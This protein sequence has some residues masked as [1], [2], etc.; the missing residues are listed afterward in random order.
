MGLI[1]SHTGIQRCLNMPEAIEAMWIASY[2]WPNLSS[3]TS[4]AIC[5]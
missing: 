5:E 1:L 2:A 3:Y 4:C